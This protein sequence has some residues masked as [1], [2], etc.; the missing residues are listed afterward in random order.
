MIGGAYLL[1]T[2]GALCSWVPWPSAIGALCTFPLAIREIKAVRNKDG[3]DLNPHLGGAARL[4][5]VFSLL[6]GLGFFL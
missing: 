3:A 2:G 6:F 1:V 4:E 5:L